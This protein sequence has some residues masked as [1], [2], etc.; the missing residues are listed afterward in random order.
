M[1]T[2]QQ[3][4]FDRPADHTNGRWCKCC[5]SYQRPQEDGTCP[6]CGCLI[7]LPDERPRGAYFD[8]HRRR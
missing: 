5:D 1:T 2:D 7:H 8:H 4:L 6:Q 3:S